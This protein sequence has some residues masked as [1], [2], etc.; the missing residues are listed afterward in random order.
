V[1]GLLPAA[2]AGIAECGPLVALLP[3]SLVSSIRAA[4]WDRG[5]GEEWSAAVAGDGAAAATAV[6][7]DC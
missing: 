4:D 3:L 1:T 7:V 5:A 6:P 2:S